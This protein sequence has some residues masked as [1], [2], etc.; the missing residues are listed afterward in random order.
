[1]FVVV[2]YFLGLQM[3]EFFLIFYFTEIL[4]IFLLEQLTGI[5][6]S[7]FLQPLTD[8]ALAQL[9]RVSDWQ[10]GGHGSDSRMLHKIKRL[11]AIASAFLYEI[12]RDFSFTLNF[13]VF[14]DSSFI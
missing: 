9:A 12:N 3:Y 4:K 5:K 1:M 11:Q 10:S 2:T 6:K 13:P 8:G 14:M 7:V